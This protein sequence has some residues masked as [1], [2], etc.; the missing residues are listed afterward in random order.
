MR[1][2]IS[3]Q[4]LAV[5]IGVIVGSSALAYDT[6]N[7]IIVGV[8][9][10]RIVETFENPN[11]SAPD[12]APYYHP[13]MPRIWRDI[14]PQGTLYLNT[15]IEDRTYTT[16]GFNTI[17]S[18]VAETGS[19]RGA[20]TGPDAAVMIN[21]SMFPSILELFN[22]RFPYER[23]FA[24]T[25]KGNATMIDF[26]FYPPSGANAPTFLIEPAGG[27]SE[28]YFAD[29]RLLPRAI[30]FLRQNHPRLGVVVFGSVDLAG[31]S[32]DEANYE[33]TIRR[34][35]TCLGTI[36]DF[37][38]SDPYYAGHTTM[39]LTSDHGRHDDRNGGFQSHGGQCDG[40]R[41]IATLVIGPDTPHGQ[42]VQRRVAQIDAAPT[43]AELLGIP[44]TLMRGEPLYEA[45]GQPVAHRPAIQFEPDLAVVGN[46]V[47][48][49]YTE[50]ADGEQNIKIAG[51]R[52]GG[53]TFTTSQV[54]PPF[55]G[56]SYAAIA[57]NP[58]VIAN[59]NGIQV[60]W[61]DLKDGPVT[62]RQSRSSLITFR[63]RGVFSFI[64]PSLQPPSI[65]E[66]ARGEG[67]MTFA[68][69]RIASLEGGSN[70]FIFAPVYPLGAI[71][72]VS[73]GTGFESHQPYTYVEP[74][75]VSY[76]EKPSIGV[77]PNGDVVAVWQNVGSQHET[78][79]GLVLSWDIF[80]SVS[81][82]NGF[83]WST[84][85][86]VTDNTTPSLDPQVIVSPDNVAHVF[87]S[88]FDA[89][90]RH[91]IFTRPFALEGQTFGTEVQ[92]TSSTVGAW[93]ASAFVDLLERLVVVYTDHSSGG[94]D[95]YAKSSFDGISWTAPVPIAQSPNI[96]QHP[97]AAQLADGD[98]FVVW[99]EVVQNAVQ[100]TRI[101]HTRA[102][103]PVS[104]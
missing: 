63:H 14:M 54:N 88:D 85:V 48:F 41:S 31:H 22:R 103:L 49:T 5:A 17:L 99:E 82:D 46:N 56:S 28:Q 15:F 92:V 35:D 43:A 75:K 52:D 71:S 26:G 45:I 102:P 7:V 98:I 65:V 83:T 57:R 70:E 10:P 30:G 20:R 24:A 69:P 61:L 101:R 3:I 25:D 67:A 11:A 32:G 21:R 37:V 86:N 64:P 72:L 73:G 90:G 44:A 104:R 94:G 81:T 18:G 76:D 19:N 39:I 80:L 74:P 29:L 62:L 23:S 55:D 91:Q 50:K 36:W 34:V 87:Y 40:C 16:P 68:T 77:G 9:G 93:Q 89:A 13:L 38:Q 100:G 1:Q 84:P 53:R 42:V 60:A 6:R 58:T 8:D 78:P 79:T 59:Q 12:Q 2:H 97:R 51:S 96:S 27:G 95:I 4:F 47:F 33:D 66:G